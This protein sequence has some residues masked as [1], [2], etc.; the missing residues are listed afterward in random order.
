[1]TEEIA[2]RRELLAVDDG[3]GRRPSVANAMV[4][5]GNG[6]AFARGRD[7]AAGSGAEADGHG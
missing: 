5:T 7:F 4:A 6:I 1:V 2:R 3:S